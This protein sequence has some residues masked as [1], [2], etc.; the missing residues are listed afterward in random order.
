MH[1]QYAQKLLIN[2]CI[3]RVTGFY[4]VEKLNGVVKFIVRLLFCRAVP[5][6]ISQIIGSSSSLLVVNGR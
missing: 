5:V 3:L 4:L 6:E 1:V 2:I